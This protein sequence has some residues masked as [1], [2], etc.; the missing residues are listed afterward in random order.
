M[1]RY[2]K[3][4]RHKGFT[5]I[6]IIT[7][8][9][10]LGIVSVGLTGFVKFG[11]DIYQDTVNRDR[12]VG[13]SRFLLERLT[14][15]LREALPNS[16][17]TDGS[18]IEFVPI[19]SS[20]T[21]ISLPV[22]PEQE[23]SFI[24]VTP[25]INS[26]N[27][28]VVYPLTPQDVYGNVIANTGKIFSLSSNIAIDAVTSQLTLPVASSFFQHSPVSRYYLV[29]NAISYCVDG[30]NVF[31]YSN[32]WPGATQESPPQSPVQGVLMASNQSNSTP[33]EYHQDSLLRNA[34]VQLNFSFTYN[35]ESL[36]IYHEVHIVNVP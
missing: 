24:V 30:T 2:P 25:A 1:S 7:V 29:E 20:S 21:Y 3:L 27:K 9:I 6:E 34:V 36:N 28:V 15:E 14:R 32:Y 10:I 12:Q 8:I 26:G 11:I 22:I 4:N 18:C 35:D 31:R 17:R 33:F 5:L 23:N 19:M 13:D 16:I